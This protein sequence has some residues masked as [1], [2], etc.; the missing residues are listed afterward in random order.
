MCRSIRANTRSLIALVALAVVPACGGSDSSG[1]V[2]IVDDPVGDTVA[3]GHARGV[4]LADLTFD[5][6][7]GNDYLVQIGMTGS[8]LASLHDGEIAVSDFAAQVVLGDDTFDFANEL[9]ID[10]EDANFELDGVMRFY[11]VGFFPAETAD[12]LAAQASF[13]IG[14]LRGSPEPD[15]DF[16]ETQVIDHASAQVLLDELY[17][18]VG[19]GAMGDYILATMDMID[20]HLAHGEALLET[21]Y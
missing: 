19:A 4:A 8:I 12:E 21:Y 13:N 14:V 7:V 11:G 17:A 10:H 6:L 16:V 2:V 15:F 5:E 9:I 18:I 3:D 1:T 20:A